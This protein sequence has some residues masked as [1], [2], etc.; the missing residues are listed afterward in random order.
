MSNKSFIQSYKHD[1]SV[2]RTWSP[3]LVIS[4]DDT[5]YVAINKRTQI[6]EANNRSWIAREPALY[7]LYK[8]HYFN[9]IAMLREDGIYYYCNLASPSMHDGEA[10]KNI[11]YDLDIKFYPNGEYEILDESEFE[12]NSKKYDYPKVIELKLREEIKELIK[13]YN[14]SETPFNE[15][16][17]RAL[18]QEYLK[19]L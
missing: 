4:E 7:Y 14:M 10:I 3:V 13:R 9:I 19:K 15:N 11:D 5:K 1:G 17:N 16:E 6:F 18:F 2:H 8:E 12:I